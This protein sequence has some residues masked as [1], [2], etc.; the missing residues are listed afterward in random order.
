M[1]KTVGVGRMRK[2]HG[3][4]KNRGS[5]PSHHVDAS[6]SVD[7]NVM[8]SLEKI[9]VLEK[10]E[11]RGGRRITQSGQRDLDRK[12]PLWRRRSRFNR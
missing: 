9:G 7:R 10:D 4:T 11:E 6:G 12:C 2:V 8:Q 3:S 5:R 1:R